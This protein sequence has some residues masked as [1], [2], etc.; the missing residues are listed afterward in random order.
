MLAMHPEDGY[1]L[2]VQTFPFLPTVYSEGWRQQRG[3]AGMTLG[4]QTWVPQSIQSPLKGPIEVLGA[5]LLPTIGRV[6][7]AHVGHALYC[8]GIGSDGAFAPARRWNVPSGAGLPSVALSRCASMT[9]RSGHWSVSLDRASFACCP[10]PALELYTVSIDRRSC[11]IMD[12][13]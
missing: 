1:Q 12:P 3:V 5:G 11:L 7:S 4:T 2:S 6:T 10:G 9:T 8:H 13:I